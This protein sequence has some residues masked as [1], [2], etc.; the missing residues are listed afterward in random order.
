MPKL[1]QRSSIAA[2]IQDFVPVF[3]RQLI[4]QKPNSINELEDVTWRMSLPR[5]SKARPQRSAAGHT[6]LVLANLVLIAP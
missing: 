1:I 3:S 4:G 2:N 5:A 6:N